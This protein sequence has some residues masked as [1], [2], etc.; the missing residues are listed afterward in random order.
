MWIKFENLSTR[1]ILSN[2]EYFQ[3]VCWAPKLGE[4]ENQ[5]DSL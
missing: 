5:L 3:Y 4:P 1:E 2:G